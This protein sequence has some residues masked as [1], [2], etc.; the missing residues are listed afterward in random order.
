MT[1]LILG[2]G[3][4][5]LFLAVKHNNLADKA[6][7]STAW[8]LF[9]MILISRSVSALLPLANVTFATI[10]L[11]SQ[12]IEWL[13]LGVSFLLLFKAIIPYDQIKST[14]SVKL[15]GNPSAKLSDSLPDLDNKDLP[16]Y[17]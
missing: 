11:W 2:Y 7:F 12:C 14:T 3:A 9:A 6:V 8:I 16:S 4:G 17:P 5:L 13:L 10:G 15:G 1:W